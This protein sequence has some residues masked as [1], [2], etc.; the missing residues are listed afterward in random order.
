MDHDKSV[1]S[2]T[3]KRLLLTFSHVY[4]TCNRKKVALLLSQLA[5][6]CRVLQLEELFFWPRTYR[7]VSQLAFTLKATNY[8]KTIFKW[9]WQS[10]SYMKIYCESSYSSN[11][12]ILKYA[13][14]LLKNWR[15]WTDLGLY[16]SFLLSN[17]KPW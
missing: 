4:Y 16:F 15:S 8:N 2:C 3:V 11:F 6:S 10:N 1:H 12:E 13:K 17:L 5:A 9:S 14:N 7:A